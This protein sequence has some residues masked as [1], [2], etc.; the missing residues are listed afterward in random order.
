MISR[1]KLLWRLTQRK[2]EKVPS[3]LKQS[4]NENI[5][6]KNIDEN[7][8]QLVRSRSAQEN[9]VDKY[10]EFHESV[11]IPFLNEL[12]IQIFGEKSEGLCVEVGAFDGKTCSNSL[13]LAK[14]GWECLLIEPISEYA[15]RA[16]A[17]HIGRNN[18]VV[19][20]QAIHSF[21][22]QLEIYTAGPLSTSSTEL[23]EEYRELD[24]ARTNLPETPD[25]RLV[26]A[27]TLN[28][29]IATHLNDRTIDVLIIDVEGGELE[30]MEGFDLNFH[31]PKMVIIE[32]PDFHPSLNYRKNVARQIFLEFIECEYLVVYKDAINTCFLSRDAWMALKI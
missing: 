20:N 23:Y 5:L 7:L 16:S 26:Q 1:L 21:A 6:H 24:W 30:V 17:E 29:F 8:S 11:Q 3:D 13:G 19:F 15:E 25:I 28:N 2:L 10:F 27:D 22:T 14:R 18:V 9:Q 32:L 31:K 4:S 12:Y